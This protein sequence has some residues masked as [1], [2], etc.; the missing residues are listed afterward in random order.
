MKKIIGDVV[1]F[2]NGCESVRFTAC[3]VSMLMRAEG[4]TDRTCDFFCDKQGGSC[5]RCGQCAD[6]VP[7][8]RKHE[9]LYN[10]YNAVAGFGFLQLDL[11]DDA[12][13]AADWNQTCNV[14]LRAFDWYIGFT[15]D[16]AGYT[17][18]EL[19]FPDDNRDEVWHKLQASIDRDVPVLAL[20]GGRYEWV[21]VTGYDDGGALYGLDGAQG[22]W[23][24]PHTKPAA[25]D[26]NGLFRMPDWYE[27]RGH[28]FI[29]GEKKAP[30]VTMR[31][32]LQRGIRIMERMH[33]HRYYSNSVDFMLDD[34]RF[35][36]LDDAALLAMRDRIAAWIGQPIDQR[37]MLGA[38]M[39]PLRA[40]K[41]PS[42]QTEALGQVHRLCWTM[43]D[44]L[45]IAW[46]GIGQYMGGEPLAW[47]RGLQ[48]PAIRRMLADCF[49]FV[50]DHDACLLD[51]LKQGFLP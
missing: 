14:L 46:R 5:I 12:Q 27:K 36:C 43:H 21:L 49:A 15:M 39:N 3:F 40:G 34:A 11:S 26:E 20:F 1:P 38:A 29:L 44:V 23:G 30:C 35:D 37:A 48:S 32:V 19:I 18:E 8:H 13:M 42:R 33:A 51:A 16:Y 22:Y 10:L 2:P 47:A 25:Y 7:L 45:W 6:M 41:A 28:A 17:Y 24:A 9:E 31:D 50:R 4:M